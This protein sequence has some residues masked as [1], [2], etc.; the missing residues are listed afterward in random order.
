MIGLINNLSEIKRIFPK[1]KSFKDYA[2]LEIGIL[3]REILNEET[4]FKNTISLASEKERTW[5]LDKLGLT[6][7]IFQSGFKFDKRH[8][9]EKSLQEFEKKSTSL[10]DQKEY[11]FLM[12]NKISS[13]EEKL[14]TYRFLK[15]CAVHLPGGSCGI[16]ENFTLDATLV[17][18]FSQVGFDDVV[19]NLGPFEQQFTEQ[20]Q[21]FTEGTELFNINNLF[22]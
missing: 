10:I 7:E 5:I 19:L 13:L 6:N 3:S 2:D 14:E 20:R 17:P 4:K 8:L 9:N 22:Y 12:K 21:F 18:D 16:T 11:P 1:L 15:F